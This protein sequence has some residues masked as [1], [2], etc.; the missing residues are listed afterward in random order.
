LIILIDL[1]RV[2]EMTMPFRTHHGR[3][4]PPFRSKEKSPGLRRVPPAI[5]MAAKIVGGVGKAP[6]VGTG[7]EKAS[8]SGV[9]LGR[10]R[11]PAIS[12]GFPLL[13]SLRAH[14][15]AVWATCQ[16]TNDRC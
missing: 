14:A 3:S 6:R 7:V 5:S 15:C 1:A 11:A 10:V 9:A 13:H 4:A 8:Y 16:P 2:R 12:A